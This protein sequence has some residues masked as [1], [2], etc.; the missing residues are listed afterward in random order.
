MAS[1]RD[2]QVTQSLPREAREAIE[3][4]FDALSEWR[5]EVSASTER[6]SETLLD[7]MAAAARALGWPKEL[8]EASHKHLAQ[9][10]KMQMHVID[11]L[12]DA[13][14]KQLTPPTSQQFLAQLRALP[15]AGLG[16]MPEAMSA[17]IDFWM[18]AAE[19]WQRNWASTMSMWTNP[20][21][22][23]SRPH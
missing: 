18:Q 23:S 7:K 12:M 20:A 15:S 3:A 9:A 19:M 17:P 2:S 1:S 10:S 8:V 11:Q 4:V 5:D 22:G 16:S 6:Y 21:S 14:Q 13:W